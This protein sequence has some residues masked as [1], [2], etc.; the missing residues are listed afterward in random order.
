MDTVA[1]FAERAL[2]TGLIL[3]GRALSDTCRWCADSAGDWTLDVVS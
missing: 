1:R 2:K 3:I